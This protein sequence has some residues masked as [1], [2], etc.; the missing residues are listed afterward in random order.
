[1]EMKYHLRRQIKMND[2]MASYMLI[3][4]TCGHMFE[5]EA[6]PDNSFLWT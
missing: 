3:Q 2:V 6:T 5:I 4:Q 1:M